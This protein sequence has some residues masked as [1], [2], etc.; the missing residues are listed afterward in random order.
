MSRQQIKILQQMAR[1]GVNPRKPF[2]FVN[3]KFIQLIEQTDNDKA[4]VVDE[5]LA[6]AEPVVISS[7]PSLVEETPDLN[8]AE[9]TPSLVEANSS[10][11]NLKK[12]K[13]VKSK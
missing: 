11:T 3:G 2:E 13:S 1:D 7:T 10:E 4:G 6:I 8:L 9:E 5:V 12:K